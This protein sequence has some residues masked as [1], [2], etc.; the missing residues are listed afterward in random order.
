MVGVNSVISPIIQVDSFP[1]K[2]SR[3]FSKSKG[4][5]HGLPQIVIWPR[6]SQPPCVRIILYFI[7]A[8]TSVYLQQPFIFAA[9]CFVLKQVFFI[10]AATFFF[11]ATFSYMLHKPI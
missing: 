3:T 1:R 11:T 8:A 9:T 6:H 10:F 7:F 2:K 4:K 5:K